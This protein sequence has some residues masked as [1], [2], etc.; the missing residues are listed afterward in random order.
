VDADAG[1]LAS[2][3][4]GF[5]GSSLFAT[6]GGMMVGGYGAGASGASNEEIVVLSLARP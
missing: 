2:P 6:T 3:F 5:A 4:I 1:Y